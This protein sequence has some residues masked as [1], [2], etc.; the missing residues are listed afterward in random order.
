MEQNLTNAQRERLKVLNTIPIAAWEYPRIIVGIPMERTLSHAAH[1]FPQFMKIAA[2]NP[3]FGWLPYM[4]TDLYR[5]RMAQTLLNSNFTHV[6]MLDV[7]HIHP[8]DIIQRLARW[9]LLY[10]HVKIVGGLNFRRGAPYEP[11]AFIEE[12]DGRVFAP[13]DWGRGLMEVDYLGTGSILIDREVFESMEPPWFFNDYSQAWE[14]NYPGEDIGFSKKARE[15]GYKLYMDTTTT[16]PHA[17]TRFVDEGTFRDYL[18]AHP[19]K[20]VDVNTKEQ[21]SMEEMQKRG[22]V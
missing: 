13:A 20:T 5:N 19:D 6:L 4:R 8:E 3:V 12:E 9:V 18:R 22:L 2:N 21:L 7:D 14:D 16:S 10:D 15:A 1:I 11:C 17:I